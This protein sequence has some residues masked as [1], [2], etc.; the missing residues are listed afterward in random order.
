LEFLKDK[1]TTSDE[2]NKKLQEFKNKTNPIIEKAEQKDKF[3]NLDKGI[4]YSLL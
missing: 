3:V 4:N 2:V 1:N